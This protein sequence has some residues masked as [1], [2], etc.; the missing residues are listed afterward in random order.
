[1]HENMCR[2]LSKSIAETTVGTFLYA[3]SYLLLPCKHSL[4]CDMETPEKRKGIPTWFDTQKDRKEG[5]E[6][7]LELCNKLVVDR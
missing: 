1:M 6:T 3:L 4:H 5:G 7:G 2:Y